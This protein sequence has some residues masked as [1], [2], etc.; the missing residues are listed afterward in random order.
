MNSKLHII[1]FYDDPNDDGRDRIYAAT[2]GSRGVF[3][4]RRKAGRWS[5]GLE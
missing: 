5:W 4:A 1:F 2:Q 3:G